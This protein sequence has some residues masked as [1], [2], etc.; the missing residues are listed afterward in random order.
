[1]MRVRFVGF[2]TCGIFAFLFLAPK[3]VYAAG[4]TFLVAP[5]RLVIAEGADSATLSVVNTGSQ[6][7]TFRLNYVNYHFDE[8]YAPHLVTNPISPWGDKFADRMLRVT[9]RYFQLPP[10]KTQTVRIQLRVPPGTTHGEYRTHLQ[11]VSVKP[12]GRSIEKPRPGQPR[13]SAAISPAMAVSVPVVVRL[14]KTEIRARLEELQLEEGQG[15]RPST[16]HLVVRRQGSQ[17]LYGD[18]KV[19]FIRKGQ[20][21][22]EPVGELNGVTLYPPGDK[23]FVAIP[24]TKK[25]LALGTLKAVMRSGELGESNRV[26][27]EGL[28]DVQ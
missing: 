8:H 25:R 13:I 21:D 5:L 28:L 18:I 10:G 4:E 14:G 16:L 2:Y 3:L 17:S 22:Q 23:L 9:P 15:E 26:L 6:T 7:G 20:L 11:V 1:M 19:F 12:A 24:L 27:A